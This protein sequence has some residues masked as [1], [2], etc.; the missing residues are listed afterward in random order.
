MGKVNRYKELTKKALNGAK[1]NIIS[2]GLY[3][4]NMRER[5]HHKLEEDLKN[6]THSLSG[7]DIF[8]EGDITTTETKLIRERFK[9]VVRSCRE[10]FGVDYIDNN[11]IIPKQM[12]LVLNA[13]N[14]EAPH[15]KRLEDLA[16]ELVMEE[17]DIPENTINFEAELRPNINRKDVNDG[18]VEV[19]DEE[20]NDYNEK[21]IANK[22]VYKRRVLNSIIQGAAK[23]VN[24]MFHMVHDELSEINP[25]L[26]GTYKQ[27]MSLA[28]Y[29][30]FSIADMDKG[31]NAGKVDVDFDSG[32]KPVIK[33]QA[34]VF[35][36][37]IHELVKGVMEVLSVNGLP[38]DKNIAEYV[39]NQADFVKA[40]PWDMRFGPVIWRRFCDAVGSEDFN[41]KHHAFSDLASM[42][43]NEFNI[44]MKEI[45][46]KTK[47][48]KE[49]MADIISNIK[50]EIQDDE[51]DEENGDNL[52]NLDELM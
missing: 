22:E 19:L 35:P 5:M 36:V 33:A 38:D 24:H 2:E 1:K 30:F 15:K 25:K 31:K 48:G 17:F 29:M 42:E 18:P 21:E 37:L 32:E 39:I 4:D 6:N 8:G 16:V 11:T 49:I 34:M 28:D 50:K 7:C 14:M 46:N 47:R 45:I 20:F 52:F 43:P 41:L 3:E 51:F 9:D 27:L 12:E 13:M 23:S 40:E 10:A 44:T 26:P